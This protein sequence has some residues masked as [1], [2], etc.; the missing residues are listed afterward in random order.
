MSGSVQTVETFTGALPQ[1]CGDQAWLEL[2]E[3]GMVNEEAE[4]VATDNSWIIFC[5]KRKQRNG[6][7]SRGRCGVK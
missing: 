4:V 3:G 2:V 5:Y 1:C 6:E 7:S